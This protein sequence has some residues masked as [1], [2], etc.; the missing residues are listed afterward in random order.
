MNLSYHSGRGG[1]TDRLYYGSSFFL[2]QQ[3][4]S[5]PFKN[6]GFPSCQSFSAEM[7]DLNFTCLHVRRITSRCTVRIEPII[8]MLR[9]L[10]I[11]IHPSAD[12][13]YQRSGTAGAF[14]CGAA[15]AVLG[16][17]NFLPAHPL[18]VQIRNGYLRSIISGNRHPQRLIEIAIINFPPMI[19]ADQG[20]AHD[21]ASCFGIEAPC[22]HAADIG[23]GAG[24]FE[25][26]PETP[27]RSVRDGEQMVE[28]D[29]MAG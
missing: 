16:K 15:V 29:P 8:A 19:D 6:F 21:I 20:A 2:L 11:F 3:V 10:N 13:R 28:D 26:F 14:S 23:V 22:Q 17:A 7:A 24:R 1:M 18:I 27:D 5:A 9:Q 12:L 4:F 25:M